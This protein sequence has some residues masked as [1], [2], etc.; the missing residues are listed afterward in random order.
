MK[1]LLLILTLSAFSFAVFAL[2]NPSGGDTA[3]ENCDVSVVS[4]GGEP[5]ATGGQP[6]PQ[7][8]GASGQ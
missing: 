3:N 7:P 5:D 4:T 6:A 1:K 2:E 8:G